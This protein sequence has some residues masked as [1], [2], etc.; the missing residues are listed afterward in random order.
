LNAKAK[1][2]IEFNPGALRQKNT[3]QR[4]SLKRGVFGIYPLK[5]N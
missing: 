3:G 5:H 2:I 4:D 1:K